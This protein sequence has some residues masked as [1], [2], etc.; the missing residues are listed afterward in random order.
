MKFPKNQPDESMEDDSEHRLDS[1]SAEGSDISDAKARLRRRKERLAKIEKSDEAS[2][3]RNR[4]IVTLVA[5]T[6]LFF[7]SFYQSKLAKNEKDKNEHTRQSKKQL[8]SSNDRQGTTGHRQT[9]RSRSKGLS[10]GVNRGS[11]MKQRQRRLT[12]AERAQR[13]AEAREALMRSE[14]D[15]EYRRARGLPQR[16]ESGWKADDSPHFIYSY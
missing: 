12:P 11:S 13:Q 6:A 8:S 14:L 5:L 2:A 3:R 15:R 10:V 9:S 4:S 16:G 7:V 1:A